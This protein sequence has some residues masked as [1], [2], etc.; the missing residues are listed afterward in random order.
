MY[1]CTN[2]PHDFINQCWSDDEQMKNHLK[3][4]F[5]LIYN[6]RK[7]PAEIVRFFHE[8]DEDNQEK[9]LKWIG[10]NYSY[11]GSD[12]KENNWRRE[13]EDAAEYI[14]EN[15][16]FTEA[17]KL[18]FQFGFY[19]GAMNAMKQSVPWWQICIM[20]GRDVTEEAVKSRESSKE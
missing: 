11:N 6:I 4:K 12:P 1:F 7:T 15:N 13:V 18:L 9:L 17:D 5:H 3:S 20:S 19:N 16:D 14:E 2:Y 10:E 8:L